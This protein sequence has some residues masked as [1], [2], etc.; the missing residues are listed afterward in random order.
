MSFVKIRT[1]TSYFISE[2]GYVFKTYRGKEFKVQPFTDENESTVYVMV[3]GRKMNLL[4]L[5]IEAFNIKVT[6]SDTVKHTVDKYMQIPL[7]SIITKRI[8]NPLTEKQIGLIK[9]FKC[10]AKANAANFRCVDNITALQVLSILE[11]HNFECI[12]C[13]TDLRLGEWHLDHFYPISKHGKNKIEN[14]VCACRTCNLMKGDLTGHQFYKMCQKIV[15]NYK[16][17][18]AVQ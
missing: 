4:Y 3:D 6:P 5:M 12:Y 2:Q 9:A 1:T 13:N 14:L 11:I 18:E 10:E 7:N 15:S 8:S 16:F 17:K